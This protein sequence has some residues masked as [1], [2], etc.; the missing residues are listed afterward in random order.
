MQAFK[1][2]DVKEVEDDSVDKGK[3]I[4]TDPTAGTTRREQALMIYVSSGD[5]RIHSEKITRAKTTRILSRT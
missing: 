2:G 4:K 5:K 3:V 1:V